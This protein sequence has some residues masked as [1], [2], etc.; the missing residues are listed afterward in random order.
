MFIFYN[1]DHALQTNNYTWKNKD[2]Y[3]TKHNSA[4][5]IAYCSFVNNKVKSVIYQGKNSSYNITDFLNKKFKKG[6]D[7]EI[8]MVSTIVKKHVDQT[9]QSLS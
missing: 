2:K 8:R 7:E 9:F 4:K 6:M 3:T 1:D 5:T